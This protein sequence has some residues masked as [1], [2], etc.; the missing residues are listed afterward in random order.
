MD[1]EPSVPYRGV[2]PKRLKLGPHHYAPEFAFAETASA[3]MASGVE[4]VMTLTP[5]PLAYGDLRVTGSS[6]K[7]VEMMGPVALT[8]VKPEGAMRVPAGTYRARRV[9]LDNG[10]EA[11][12][13]IKTTVTEDEIATLAVGGPL[14]PRIDVSRVGLFLRIE[15]TGTCG[16]GG[17]TYSVPG[18]S[19]GRLDGFLVYRGDKE[20]AAGKF[21]YG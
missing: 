6:V 18:S 20:I 4:V 15:P 17:E 10:A 12:L 5:S 13:N 14:K 21:R 8:L 2:I 3:E 19:R 1:Y 7:S 11:L 9:V 16:I